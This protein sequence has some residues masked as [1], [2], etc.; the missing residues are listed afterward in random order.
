MTTIFSEPFR[1]LTE[2]HAAWG[3]EQLETFNEFLP[4][5][6][7]SA[8]LGRC[9]YRQSGRELRISLLGSY[10]VNEC[11]WLWSWANPGFASSPAAAAAERLRAYGQAHGLPEFTEELVRLD[12]HEDPGTAAETLAF[13]AMGV[14]GAAGYIGV[15]ASPDARAYLVPDDPQV[16]R[17]EPDAITLPRVLLTGVSLLGGS[18]RAATEGYVV[19]HELPHRAAADRLTAGLPDGG[20][21]DVV[22]DEHDRIASV[23]VNT[24]APA[25]S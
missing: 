22:F 25:A 5:G 4:P 12:G 14:L 18:G 19:H 23:H 2:R 9:L 3:A 16:P 10:E 17:A 1:R 8:D 24:G 21:V 6:E 15:R 13:T 11:S 20:T 7:W